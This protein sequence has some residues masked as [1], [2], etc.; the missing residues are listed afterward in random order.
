VE[1]NAS[2]T[3]RPRNPVSTV[4]LPEASTILRSGASLGIGPCA[5]SVRLTSNRNRPIFKCALLS[6]TDVAAAPR[7]PQFAPGFSRG[8]STPKRRRNRAEHRKHSSQTHTAVGRR[9]RNHHRIHHQ[10]TKQLVQ[11]PF[12]NSSF[13]PFVPSFFASARRLGPP[14]CRRITVKSFHHARDEDCWVSA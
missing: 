7:P 10:A 6:R 3:T 4:V 8:S 11:D 1:T 5:T 2:R 14:S 13:A 12:R 9:R